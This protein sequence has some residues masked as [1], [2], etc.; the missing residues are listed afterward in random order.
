MSNKFDVVE[1]L[2]FVI[3]SLSHGSRMIRMSQQKPNVS[4]MAEATTMSSA[5]RSS[6]RW[7]EVIA[8]AIGKHWCTGCTLA[9]IGIQGPVWSRTGTSRSR[10]VHSHS[11]F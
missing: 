6:E 8:I 10:I 9:S 1:L 5:W 3:A 2:C 11:P 4:R 7:D